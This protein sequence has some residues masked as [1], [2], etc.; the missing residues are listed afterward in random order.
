M[1]QETSLMSHETGAKFERL[2]IK[3]TERNNTWS[4]DTSA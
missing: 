4:R 3:E 1:D 2:N